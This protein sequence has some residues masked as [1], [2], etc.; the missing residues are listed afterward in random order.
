[1][2]RAFARS[3]LHLTIDGC[4]VRPM[5]ELL[6]WEVRVQYMEEFER[7]DFCSVGDVLYGTRNV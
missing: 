1:M 4:N 2:Y 3:Q 6:N 5:S 7:T